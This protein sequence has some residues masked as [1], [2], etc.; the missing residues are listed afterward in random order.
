MSYWEERHVVTVALIRSET[1]N[2]TD[3]D[4]QNTCHEYF[5]NNIQIYK[6][7]RFAFYDRFYLN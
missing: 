2:P 1:V 3:P 5:Q 6:F 7:A 4:T